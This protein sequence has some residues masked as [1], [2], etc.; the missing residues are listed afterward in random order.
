MPNNVENSR[1][2]STREVFGLQP[3]RKKNYR[4]RMQVAF[5]KHHSRTFWHIDTFG[6]HFWDTGKDPPYLSQMH[7]LCHSLPLAIQTPWIFPHAANLKGNERCWSTSWHPAQ[8]QRMW[9]RK[10]K[11]HGPKQGCSEKNSLPTYCARAW[12]RTGTEHSS[13]EEKILTLLKEL[14][15]Y[16][17]YSSHV[18]H[19]VPWRIPWDLTTQRKSQPNNLTARSTTVPTTRGSSL[20]LRSNAMAQ[21]KAAHGNGSIPLPSTTQTQGSRMLFKPLLLN[22]TI[23]KAMKTNCQ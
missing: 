14:T 7:F 21:G 16:L 19:L 23:S 12:M 6:N 5:K 4:N 13:T 10:C 9:Y 1:L 20:L 17:G 2:M 15:Q 18:C 22:T 8:L 3:L 11:K